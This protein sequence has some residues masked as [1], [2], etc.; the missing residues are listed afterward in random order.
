MS[1]E[2]TLLIVDDDSILLLGTQRVLERHGYNVKTTT[3]GEKAVELV[4]ADRSIDMVLMDIDLGPG[5]DGTEAAE[6][7]LRELDLP[8]IFVSSHTEPEVVE[9]T[10][11]ITSY[12]YVVKNAGETVLCASIKMAFRLYNARRELEDRE[13]QAEDIADSVPGLVYS[14]RVDPSGNAC[15]TYISEGVKEF[16][17]ISPREVMEDPSLIAVAIP[18][19]SVK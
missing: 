10:E 18:T 5:M 13:R 4:R 7:I 11:G 12:G 8:L 2:F 1:G 15:Y 9:K 17:G 16:Y 6:T 19:G 3:S 14:Y